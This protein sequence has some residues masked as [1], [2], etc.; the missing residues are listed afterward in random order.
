MSYKILYISPHLSTGGC[1]QYLLKKMNVLKDNH[2]IYCVEYNNYGECFVV[3]KNQVREMLKDK[4]FVLSDNK[5]ELLSIIKNI[6]P[7]IIHLEEMPEYFMSDDIAFKVYVKGRRYNIVETSHDSSFNVANKRHFPDRFIFVSE[8]QKRRM[9]ILGIPSHVIEYPILYKNRSS[10]R[11]ESLIAMDLDPSLFHVLN[12]GLWSSRK[13]QGE[14]VKYAKKL[15]DKPIQFHFVGNTAGNFQDYWSPILSN[16]PSNCKVWGERKD[17]DT[18]YSCM[19]LFL[20]TSRGNE[21]DKET[22][23]IVIR[24]AISYRIPSLIYNLPVYLDMYDKYSNISYLSDKFD[25]N[26]EKLSSFVQKKT[27]KIDYAY[28]VSAYPSTTATSVTTTQCLKSL[29]MSHKILATHHINYKMFE[30]IADTIVYDVDNPIIKH[31]YYSKYWYQDSAFRCDLNLKAND[32]NK[33][34]GLAVWTNYQNGIRKSKEL[35]YRYSVCLNYD[36]VLNQDDLHTVHMMVNELTRK[37]SKGFFMYQQMGEGDTLKT[38]FF[39]IDNDYFL[40]KFD[41]IRTESEYNTSI[42]KHQSSSNSLENYVYHVMK[43]NLSDLTIV[44]KTEEDLFPNSD[45]NAFSCVEYFSVVPNENNTSFYIWKSSSN[46][47]DNKNIIIR[48][49]ENNRNILKIG[50]LQLNDRRVYHEVKIKS[51]CS[52]AVTLE[53]YNSNHE[54]INEKLIQFLDIK[55]IA[56][57]GKFVSHDSINLNLTSQINVHHINKN[58]VSSDSIVDLTTFGVTYRCYL[59][60]SEEDL[61]KRLYNYSSD[62]N[63]VLKNV[64]LN[65]T[66]ERFVHKV[67]SAHSFMVKNNISVIALVSGETAYLGSDEFYKSHRRSDIDAYVI[68]HMFL[69]KFKTIQSLNEFNTYIKLFSTHAIVKSL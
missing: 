63:V 58:D 46:I 68:N 27:N 67:K 50:Y 3:Q 31:S 47:V 18:F 44:N 7:D 65:V 41:S 57:N 55:E 62:I 14:I 22:S 36:I 35:G 29:N 53:E 28:V 49:Y 51:G 40:E 4:Y 15:I 43:N 25:E 13:N 6:D 45:L 24:E 37:S 17:V 11:N 52:Y 64:E 66:S 2:Q 5:E 9:D 60:I 38:V 10:D 42:I 54:R 16:L 26:V 1:P 39:I 12:V 69:N 33:Y 34:H 61:I 32:N 48:V 59:D 23:P 30:D 19:D 21:N 8:Y 56:D 20:F